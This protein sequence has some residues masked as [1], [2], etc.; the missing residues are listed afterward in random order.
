MGRRKQSTKEMKN[1]LWN[2]QP[3]LD[4]LSLR[5]KQFKILESSFLGRKMKTKQKLNSDLEGL[6]FYLNR[7]SAR[8]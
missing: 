3:V 8:S 6:D 5:R 2:Q 4:C 7:L 1:L